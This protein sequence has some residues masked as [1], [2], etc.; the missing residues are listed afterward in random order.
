MSN[1]LGSDV[2]TMLVGTVEINQS[3]IGRAQEILTDALVPDGITDK[4]AISQ[5]LELFDGPHQR[6]VAEKTERSVSLANEYL[7]LSK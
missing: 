2:V 5:L 3:I 4:E 7:E 1:N 6:L